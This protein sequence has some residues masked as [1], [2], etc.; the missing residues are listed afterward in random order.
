MARSGKSVTVPLGSP[1][2]CPE[3]ARGLVPPIQASEPML[4]PRMPL[5]VPLSL[6][7]AGL[8]VL[9]GAVFLGRELGQSQSMPQTQPQIASLAPSRLTA[10]PVA[11]PAPPAKVA[12]AIQPIVVASALPAAPAAPAAPMP[13]PAPATTKAVPA[14]AETDAPAVQPIK[15]AIVTAAPSVAALPAA[16]VISPE[17]AKPLAL[18]AVKPVAAPAPIPPVSQMPP[19]AL[20]ATPVEPDE[21]FSPVPVSGGTPAYPVD[22]AADGRVGRVTITCLI[23]ADG[24]AANCHAAPGKGSGAFVA[25]TLAWLARGH[26]HFHPVILHGH[27]AAGAHTWPVVVE[28]PAA[29]LADAR[30]KQHDAEAAL[31]AGAPE[32]VP[33]AVQAPHA[34]TALTV[35]P[36]AARQMVAA[37]PPAA[38]DTRQAGL[39]Q[40][41]STRVVA[42][43]TPV[44]PVS[45][46]QNRPGAVTVSCMIGTD[47][48]A[49]GCQVV[50][51]KGGAAFGWA[52]KSWLSSG[53]V[54]FRPMTSQGQP[55]SQRK[56]WTIVFNQMPGDD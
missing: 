18:A 42:G 1:F 16:P 29:E 7:G 21:P 48:A 45:Y 52:V 43:G 54:R 9:G 50:T 14:V 26:V 39:D 6:V 35:L 30:R 13:A 4:P 25:P 38:A 33:A 19:P 20:P 12:V 36:V 46:D 32:A 11:S 10:T 28:E 23:Q 22:L 41:F 8:L 24:V 2:I 5:A 53:R 34:A 51:A 37:P 40:P 55:V 3:C 47:G 31:A 49:S 17:A 15:P 56:S 27:P 44:F